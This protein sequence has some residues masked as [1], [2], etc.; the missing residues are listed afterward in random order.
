MLFILFLLQR[1]LLYRIFLLI[2]LIRHSAPL[3]QRRDRAEAWLWFLAQT[4]VARDPVNTDS[5]D[6]YP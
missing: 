4:F 5:V 3:P 2:I 6:Q 1:R